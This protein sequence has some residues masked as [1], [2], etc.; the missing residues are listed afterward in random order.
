MLN[1]P[2]ARYVPD[3]AFV[4]SLTLRGRET[5][6]VE[7]Q[8]LP[9]KLR[10]GEFCVAVLPVARVGLTRKSASEAVF[11]REDRVYLPVPAISN[12]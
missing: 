12:E 1:D 7:F 2:D 6:V 4:Y 3:V 8:E 10:D 9:P 11:P 5:P